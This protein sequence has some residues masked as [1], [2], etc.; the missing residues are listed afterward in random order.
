MKLFFLVAVHVDRGAIVQ[1]NPPEHLD[2]A[3]A[4]ELRATLDDDSARGALG[5]KSALVE[6]ISAEVGSYA[7][8][9]D[10]YDKRMAVPKLPNV[11][12]KRPCLMLTVG[13]PV[14]H[15]GDKAQVGIISLWD[16]PMTGIGNEAYVELPL[17]EEQVAILTASGCALRNVVVR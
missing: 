2:E 4:S 17:T 12:A 6:P 3:I 14:E 10:A 15:G 13:L 8:R 1:D 9:C 16:Q 5:I 7:L 11:I